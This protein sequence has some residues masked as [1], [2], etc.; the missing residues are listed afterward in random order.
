MEEKNVGNS[1]AAG[2]IGALEQRAA[3]EVNPMPPIV[4]HAF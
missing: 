1:C 2:V 4:A 3:T